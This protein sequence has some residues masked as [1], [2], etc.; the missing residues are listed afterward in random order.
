MI[1]SGQVLENPG[2]YRKSDRIRAST[3]EGSGASTGRVI[4]FGQVQEESKRVPE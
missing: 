2:K 1:E 3:R 4:E